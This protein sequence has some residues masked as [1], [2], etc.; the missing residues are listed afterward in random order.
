[1]NKKRLRN[2]RGDKRKVGWLAV[3]GIFLAFILLIF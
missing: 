2:I 3:F 1:M